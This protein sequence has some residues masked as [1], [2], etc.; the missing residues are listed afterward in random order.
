MHLDF[1][2]PTLYISLPDLVTLG[3]G[4]T[5]AESEAE[6]LELKDLYTYS[7]LGTKTVLIWTVLI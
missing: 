7:T 3:S 5:N 4:T 1:S 2:E 6:N